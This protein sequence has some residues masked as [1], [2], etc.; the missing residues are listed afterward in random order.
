MIQK[1]RAVEDMDT[2]TVFGLESRGYGHEYR[3]Q[4]EDGGNR[5]FLI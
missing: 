5:N 3:D 2:D 4:K 1:E